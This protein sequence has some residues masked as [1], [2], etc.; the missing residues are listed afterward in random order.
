MFFGVF[1]LDWR[2]KEIILGIIVDHGLGQDLVFLV[3]LGGTK[4][5][6]RK[7]VV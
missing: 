7:S 5:L 3:T 2:R 6:D 4:L 1:L